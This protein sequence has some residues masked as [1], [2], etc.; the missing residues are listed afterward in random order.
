MPL[1][2]LHAAADIESFPGRN[3]KRRFQ[4]GKVHRLIVI[5]FLAV[6]SIAK[7]QILLV[8][9]RQSLLVQD[10]C[11]FLI[12]PYTD[13]ELAGCHLLIV[14]LICRRVEVYSIDRIAHI[15]QQILH[16][17]ERSAGHGHS[18]KRSQKRIISSYNT[19][20]IDHQLFRQRPRK[21]VFV[22]RL[23]ISFGNLGECHR[24]KHENAR[25]EHKKS[26]VFHFH[27]NYFLLHLQIFL[28]IHALQR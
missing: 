11:L 4:F 22:F 24:A 3:H 14:L 5:V 21:D 7:A 13:V 6:H 25:K 18:I 9:R 17:E 1:L 10:F 26:L 12:A 8:D 27:R 15:R 19:V 20:I 16:I 28:L 2:R 23:V